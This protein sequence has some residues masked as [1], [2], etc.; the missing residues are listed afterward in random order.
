MNDKTCPIW[1]TNA[2]FEPKVGDYEIVNSPRAGG[3]Y[4]ISGSQIAT[5]E[6]NQLSDIQKALL[7]SELISERISGND[8]PKIEEGSIQV[9]EYR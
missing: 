8:L 3:R 6:S 9:I 5:L 4:W 7:T 1:G 2:T